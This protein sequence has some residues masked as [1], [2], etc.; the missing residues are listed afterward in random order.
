MRRIL[1]PT[2]FSPASS[3]AFTQAVT[4][5]KQHGAELVIAHVLTPTLP[6]VDRYVGQQIYGQIEAA[7]RQ[8]GRKRLDLLVS[9]A[10][11]MGVRA[12]ALLLDGVAH[13]RI[14]RAARAQ[15]AALIVLG[16]R[17][18]TG[19]AR[20]ALGSVAGRVVALARCPVLT[21]RGGLRGAGRGDGRLPRL[22]PSS[23]ASRPRG[24]TA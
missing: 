13:D 6:T 2:D 15:R 20:V 4:L 17:G 19:L 3:A 9:R 7:R 8:H 1:H 14:V 16:T 10:R 22:A 11:K 12:R 5:A 21:V 18:R 24:L 23:L